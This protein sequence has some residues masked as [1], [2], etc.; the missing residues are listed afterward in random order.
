MLEGYV[1][2]ESFNAA[3]LMPGD[4]AEVDLTFFGGQDYR[5]VVC[6]QANLPKVE[7]QVLDKDKIVVFDNREKGLA[8]YFDFRMAGT[9]NLTVRLK[10]PGKSSASGMTAQGCVALLVG[11]KA[12]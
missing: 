6:G 2:N 4:E 10:V 5:L 7:F 9:Q 11:R 3:R 1:V 12:D 8:E